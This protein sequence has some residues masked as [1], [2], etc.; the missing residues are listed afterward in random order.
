MITARGVVLVRIHHRHAL[1]R[2]DGNQVGGSPRVGASRRNETG[3][4]ITGGARCYV[5]WLVF[6]W[7]WLGARWRGSLVVRTG[8]RVGGTGTGSPFFPWPGWFSRARGL[9]A[10]CWN[11]GEPWNRKRWATARRREVN[12][13]REFPSDER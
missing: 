13:R 11:G 9:T 7:L 12:D 4:R 8:S 1:M 5:P 10:E 2:S 3:W 6:A